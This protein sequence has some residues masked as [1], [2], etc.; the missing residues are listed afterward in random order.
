VQGL[1]EALVSLASGMASLGS[2]V[3][4]ATFGFAAMTWVGLGISMLPLV[5]FLVYRAGQALPKKPE[6]SLGA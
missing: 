4:F 2:G 1:T 3:L 5:L 6:I